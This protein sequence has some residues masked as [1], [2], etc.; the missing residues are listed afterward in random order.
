[1]FFV[2]SLSEVLSYINCLIRFKTKEKCVPLQ[3]HS[4]GILIPDAFLPKARGGV[5][6]FDLDIGQPQHLKFR[7]GQ[8]F[9]RWLHPLPRSQSQWWW[10][11]GSANLIDYKRGSVTDFRLLGPVEFMTY[12]NFVRAFNT[13]SLN[14][15]NV[16]AFYPSPA[17]SVSSFKCFL[18]MGW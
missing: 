9:L 7:A 4:H 1:M 17:L 18:S 14:F 11:E 6:R 2:A 16:D 15:G 3:L 10:Q 8:S 5:R 13:E 12:S